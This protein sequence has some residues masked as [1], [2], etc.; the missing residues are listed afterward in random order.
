[1]RHSTE[2]VEDLKVKHIVY[3]E[4]SKDIMKTCVDNVLLCFP[5]ELLEARECGTTKLRNIESVRN[6]R[7]IV[8]ILIYSNHFFHLNDP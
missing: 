1:M 5:F 8:A 3:V 7:C 2:N 4:F 6:P